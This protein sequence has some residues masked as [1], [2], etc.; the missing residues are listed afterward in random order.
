MLH[1]LSLLL[2]HFHANRVTAQ[3]RNDD[4]WAGNDKWISLWMAYLL[5]LALTLDVIVPR[6]NVH[7]SEM[8]GPVSLLC[9]SD[10]CTLSP[11]LLCILNLTVNSRQCQR[12][13]ASA[14]RENHGRAWAETQTG[15]SGLSGKEG[16]EEVEEESGWTAGGVNLSGIQRGSESGALQ[17]KHLQAKIWVYS[18]DCI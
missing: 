10:S 11:G 5:K 3:R 16:V 17:S 1:F 13:D 18:A 8:D 7:L 14:V 12:V 4:E 9:P 15:G 6:W 2:S